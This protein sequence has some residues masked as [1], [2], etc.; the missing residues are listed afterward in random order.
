[1]IPCNRFLFAVLLLL[2][3]TVTFALIPQTLASPGLYWFQVG[4]GESVSDTG[5]AVDIHVVQQT[6]PADG[7]TLAFWVGVD[8]PNDAFIQVGYIVCCG[9]SEPQGF[10]EYFPAGTA[11]EGASTQFLGGKTPLPEYESWVHF[12][13][14]SNGNTW[15]AYINNTPIGSAKLGMNYGID[16]HAVAEDAGTNSASNMIK[17]VEFRNL[18]YRD[19]SGWHAVSPGDAISDFGVGS[20]V[21]GGQFPYGIQ[22]TVGINN[23]WMAGS[24]LPTVQHDQILWPWYQVNVEGLP[25]GWTYPNGWAIYNSL[26]DLSNVP[27]VIIP[28]DT[29]HYFLEGWYVNGVLEPG[30]GIFYAT[31]NMTLKPDYVQQWLVQVNSKL[32]VPV[33]SGWYNDGATATVGVS[34]AFILAS[35]ILG[36]FEVGSTLTGWVGYNIPIVNGESRIQ[37]NSSMVLTATWSTSYGVLSYYLLLLIP[38]IAAAFYIHRLERRSN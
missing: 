38:A 7:S 8:I 24:G 5:A 13:L 31:E 15:T 6:P 21:Y 16:A 34:P 25:A 10:W 12:S 35:G 17:P 2:S 9:Q 26:I 37:V 3:F 14:Q 28:Q 19:S 18:Q 22:T 32:G 1:M 33:G 20:A 11:R 36:R 30:I 4:A 29:S 27:K 23:D